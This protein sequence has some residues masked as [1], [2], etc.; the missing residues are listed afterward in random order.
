MV[1]ESVDS[2]CVKVHIEGCT[3]GGRSYAH[4]TRRQTLPKQKLVNLL[5]RCLHRRGFAGA[6]GTQEIEPQGWCSPRI[7]KVIKHSLNVIQ[8]QLNE[9]TL[10]SVIQR[11][12][13][14]VWPVVS[15]PCFP[16][17]L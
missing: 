6:S 2:R 14:Q 1:D 7:I 15:D 10:E 8:N 4:K 17:F 16:L 5:Q 9:E 3:A 13:G 11:L 12:F